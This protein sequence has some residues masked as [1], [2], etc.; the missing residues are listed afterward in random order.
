[1][2]NIRNNMSYAIVK[3]T[4]KL[5]ILL[6]LA[7]LFSSVFNIGIIAE[8]G[9]N[10]PIIIDNVISPDTAIERYEI[11]INVFI[12]NDGTEN[13]LE[14]EIID[15][16]LFVDDEEP[17]AAHNYTSEGLDVDEIRS[18]NLSWQTELGDSPQRTLQIIV[19]YHDDNDMWIESIEIIERNTDL[20]F[21]GDMVIDGQPRVGHPISINAVAKNIGRS[22]TEEINATLFI[23]GMFYQSII[24]DGL[25]KDEIYNLS[26]EWIPQNFVTSLVNLSL[27]LDK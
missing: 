22:T 25:S 10:S 24:I 5:S 27:D 18:V 3:N 11:I 21:D 1:M 20:I 15:V 4:N 2:L 19:E 23:A 8:E 26:F 13:I 6:I 14:G 7:M 16:F 12:K 17:A 9:R